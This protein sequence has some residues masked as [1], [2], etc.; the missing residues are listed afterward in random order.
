M[1]RKRSERETGSVFFVRLSS[2]LFLFIVHVKLKVT[3][4]QQTKQTKERATKNNIYPVSIC[5]IRISMVFLYFYSTNLQKEIRISCFL[6]NWCIP[7]STLLFP[8]IIYDNFCVECTL[9]HVN[10]FTI[11]CVRGRN[12]VSESE[13]FPTRSTIFVSSEKLECLSVIVIISRNH[14]G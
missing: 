5:R 11:S 2:F 12:V 14:L 8:G 13:N 6:R 4:S 7:A 3:T 1:L 9:F 10:R